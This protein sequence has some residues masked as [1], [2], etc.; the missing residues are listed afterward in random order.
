MSFS[1]I[2]RRGFLASLST[3]VVA[4]SAT[5]WTACS[6]SSDLVSADAGL[7]A[8]LYEAA[9]PTQDA[10]P[11]AA[12]DLGDGGVAPQGK[13]LVASPSV[14]ILG[15]TTDGYAVY[16]DRALGKVYTIPLAG[17]VP[18]QVGPSWDGSSTVIS[19]YGSVVLYWTGVDFNRSPLIGQLV[20]WTASGH[21]R[22]LAPSSIAGGAA[23]SADGKLIAYSDA[24]VST[25]PAVDGGTVV[26]TALTDFVVSAPDGSGKITMA[27]QVQWSSG[28]QTK[29]AFAGSRVVIAA[30]ASVNPPAPAATLRAYAGPSFGAPVTLN[31]QPA[32]T[33]FGY[34]ANHVIYF[35]SSTFVLTTQAFGSSPIPLMGDVCNSILSNDG[36]F[37]VI[38]NCN[39]TIYR[40]STTSGLIQ[41]ISPGYIDLKRISP[42]DKWLLASKT[43]DATLGLTDLQLLSTAPNSTATPLVTT[44]TAALLKDSFTKDNSRVFVGANNQRAPVGY[45][46]DVAVVP[47]SAPATTPLTISK[48]AWDGYATK[49]STI[50]YDDG[51]D[52]VFPDLPLADI[53][54]IDLANAQTR[55]K[56]VSKADADFFLDDA[57]TKAVYTWTYCADGRAGLYVVDLP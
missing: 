6:N 56:L 5:L 7:D 14:R 24:T 49:G 27:S 29:V 44:P 26:G 13:Q 11:A 34:D 57:R 30:C 42:D 16:Q 19:I 25:F 31:N 38:R 55:T 10:G 54:V 15:V 1:S 33:G 36:S 39:G 23:V 8:P 50:I 45:F 17:G 18:E 21:S 22:I 46:G 40:A 48:T 3:I 37:I 28:C 35:I 51:Y 20:V 53:Q 9:P 41:V 52:L 47:L 32:Y 12:C 2:S 43:Y 4:C